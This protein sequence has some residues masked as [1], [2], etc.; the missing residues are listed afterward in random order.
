VGGRG[1][2]TGMREVGGG[3][4]AALNNREGWGCAMATGATV[5]KI[6]TLTAKTIDLFTVPLL[7]VDNNL[8]SY[9]INFV[10]S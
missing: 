10:R 5:L 1:A 2:G 4:G 3:G 6:K 7:K 9:F 8:I